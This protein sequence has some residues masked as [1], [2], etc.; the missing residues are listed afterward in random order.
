MYSLQQEQKPILFSQVN[1]Y[2]IILCFKRE[3]YYTDSWHAFFPKL[4]I[5]TV[6]NLGKSLSCCA[7]L[8]TGL[9]DGTCRWQ[10]T[11]WI[12][13]DACGCRY[14]LHTR[15]LLEE[16]PTLVRSSKQVLL[17]GRWSPASQVILGVDCLKAKLTDTL[18]SIFSANI[19]VPPYRTGA[20][21]ELPCARPRSNP[22]QLL[23]RYIP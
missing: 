14:S 18:F 19:L 21:R 22:T 16:W 7:L 4:H 5:L 1:V 13:T 3:C 20:S 23:G 12:E 17:D 10:L 6:Q 2:L 8:N 11:S 9:G 15:S